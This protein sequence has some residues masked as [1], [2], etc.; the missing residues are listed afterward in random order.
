MPRPKVVFVAAMARDRTLA[1]DGELPWH[2]PEDLRFF[3]EV[4]RGQTVVMGRRTLESMGEGMPGRRNIVL[5]RK[6]AEVARAF[7][8]VVVATSPEDAFRLA[9]DAGAAVVYVIGGGEV[10]ASTMTY[11]DEILLTL[12]P[13]M[14]GGDVFMPEIP[15]AD[16][17]EASR[18]P[19]GACT[20]VRYVRR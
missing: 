10:F 18:E 20:L 17:R 15:D 8:E 19:L 11:A 3:D 13:E 4:T 16:W 9:E 7:P 5:A 14:G 12:V 1:K 2:H 6:P